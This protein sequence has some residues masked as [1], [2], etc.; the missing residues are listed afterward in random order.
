MNQEDSK[1]AVLP[2]HAIEFWSDADLSSHWV[3]LAPILRVRLRDRISSWI[4]A[5]SFNRGDT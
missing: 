5:V 3:L 2:Q 4:C 1:A